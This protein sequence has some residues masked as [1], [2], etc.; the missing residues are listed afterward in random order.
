[1]FCLEE[2]LPSRTPIA[3]NEVVELELT[4]ETGTLGLPNDQPNRQAPGEPQLSKG[5]RLRRKPSC[6]HCAVPSLQDMAED[7]ELRGA[8]II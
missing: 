6:N 4:G 7:P 5:A 2:N 8:Q 3:G 1:M